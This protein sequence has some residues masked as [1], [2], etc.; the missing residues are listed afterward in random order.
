MNEEKTEVT[1]KL[2]GNTEVHFAYTPDEHNI[3]A[4]AK[5]VELKAYTLH[6]QK[7]DP[8]GRAFWKA[9]ERQANGWL[10][11]IAVTPLSPEKC[12]KLIADI[13]RLLKP[14]REQTA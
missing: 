1:I 10:A 8:T 12:Q 9:R 6:K 7:F 2:L 3:A 14:K 11:S 4:A 5:I 13:E